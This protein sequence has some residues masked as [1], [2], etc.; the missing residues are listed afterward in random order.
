MGN[1]SLQ[2]G[3]IAARS[4]VSVDTV[5]YYERLKLVPPAPRS[6]SGYRI[7]ST[8]AIEQIRF[9]KQAQELGF[10]LD[11]IKGLL[12]TGGAKECRQVRDL[13]RRKLCEMDEQIKKL[14]AFRKIL[15]GHLYD[16]DDEFER[17]GQDAQCPVL[18]EIEK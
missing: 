4:G 8:K 1:S 12:T 15:A 7:F 9:I 3:E 10:S 16:C 14:K 2:I 17:K 5:R 13:L 6:S 18:F 11:E